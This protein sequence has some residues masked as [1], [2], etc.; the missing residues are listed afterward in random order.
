MNNI[1]AF[2]LAEK[3]CMKYTIKDIKGTTSCSIQFYGYCDVMTHRFL[4][5]RETY[6][7]F[8]TMRKIC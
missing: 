3:K 7:T 4:I 1:F 2:T 6:V 8:V 5:A